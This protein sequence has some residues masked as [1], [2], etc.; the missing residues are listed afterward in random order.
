VAVTEG[1]K[2]SS[3]RYAFPG[4]SSAT[5]YHAAWNMFAGPVGNTVG[6]YALHANLS[7]EQLEV[8]HLDGDSPNDPNGT[9]V[10]ST[11]H[12]ESPWKRPGTHAEPAGPGPVPAAPQNKSPS[13]TPRS[14]CT[15]RLR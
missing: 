4:F 6:V 5:G 14:A 15:S 10:T 11:R 3:T 12:Q 7:L 8:R 9:F 13:S 2:G 1:W